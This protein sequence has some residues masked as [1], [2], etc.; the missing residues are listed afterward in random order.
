MYGDG[1]KGDISSEYGS[2]N[3][4]NNDKWHV[5][6]YISAFVIDDDLKMGDTCVGNFSMNNHTLYQHDCDSNHGDVISVCGFISR[7]TLYTC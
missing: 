2:M 4:H 6:Y 7:H 3:S 5:Y 1:D